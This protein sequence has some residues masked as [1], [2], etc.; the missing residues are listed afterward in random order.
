MKI[1]N[2][3]NLDEKEKENLLKRPAVDLKASFEAV[4]PI[5]DEVKRDG[6][7]AALKYAEKFDRFPGGDLRVS[8]A[9]FLEAE[10]NLD[11][12]V[13]HSIRKAAG[14]IEKFHIKQL[15]KPYE[16]ETMEGIL[17]SREYRAIEN[18]GLYIPGG[19]AVL[20]STMLM[21]GIPARI[22]GCKRI[23]AVSPSKGNRVNDALLFAAK[24]LGITEFYKVGGVQ[25]IGLLAYGA[26]GFPKVNK[27]FGPG[28]QYVTAAK[29]LVSIDL[30]GC[31]ID[32]PA[33]P[34][35]VL[36]VADESSEPSFVAADLLSQAE[37]GPDSQVVLAATSQKVLS[38]VLEQLE[39]QLL[40]LPRK[41]IA[42]RAL[43][44]SFALLTESIGDAISFSNMYAPEHLILHVEEP[45][46]YKPLITNAG[47]VFLGGYSPESA[48][49]YASGTNHSLP[50]Y[51]Y[52]KSFG[53]VSV[54]SFMKT[55]TFQT[56]TREGLRS[57]AGAIETLAETESLAA[58]KNAVTIRLNKL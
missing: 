18:V 35:E 53:G 25:A 15:P 45:E 19:S 20:P 6:L 48:G 17:C 2:F 28:N 36:V 40:L 52:A 7:K 37:H 30:N 16:T 58:H 13:K 23:V 1:F 22:A 34:S 49:D 10:K 4:K 38:R 43:E 3:R 51:G 57:I 44:S 31:P 32:M 14:N 24:I 33:G 8:E 27:I 56:L 47:S 5:L 11:G 39:S 50:T 26:E 55:M 21:L 12:E 9:E 29:L 46:S 42:V 41:D 54:E